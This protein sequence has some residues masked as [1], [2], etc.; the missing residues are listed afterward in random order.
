MISVFKITK[1]DENPNTI[2]LI[3]NP[4]YLSTQ[5]GIVKT[6]IPQ[7]TTSTFLNSWTLQEWKFAIHPVK[8]LPTILA[9]PI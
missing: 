4:S 8:S 1:E 2:A 6:A 5:N 9:I 7:I 3:T